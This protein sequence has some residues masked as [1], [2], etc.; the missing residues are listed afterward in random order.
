[1][2]KEQLF[3]HKWYTLIIVTFIIL[4]ALIDVKILYFVW[5]VPT[6]L[7]QLSQYNF[8]YFGHMYGY[9]N[10]NTADDSKNNKWLFPAILGEAWHNNHHGNPLSLT[11]QT[12]W[13]EIDPAGYIIRIIKK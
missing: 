5:I 9:R 1:M 3:I 12:R 13:W 7:I 10:F 2:S 8:N 4:L 6:F 11:T